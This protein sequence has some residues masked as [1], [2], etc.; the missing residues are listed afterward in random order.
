MDAI[1]VSSAAFAVVTSAGAAFCELPESARTPTPTRMTAA[2]LRPVHSHFFD[3][4]AKEAEGAT[5]PSRALLGGTVG[6]RLDD[7][8]LD[9]KPG[10]G[11]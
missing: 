3:G 11:S 7:G 4:G 6:V 8:G 2:A 10:E 9:R 1:F 5:S